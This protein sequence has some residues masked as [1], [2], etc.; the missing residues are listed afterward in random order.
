MKAA[1]IALSITFYCLSTDIVL[2]QESTSKA[3]SLK[4]LH[5]NGWVWEARPIINDL[6]D[7]QG[8]IV[9]MITINQLGKI[10][11]IKVIECTVSEKTEKVYREGTSKL[12]FRR[13]GTA[14]E[15][16]ELVTGTITYNIMNK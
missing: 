8:K 14:T 11:D 2:G 16:H 9:Y 1:I 10:E 13:V 7:D 12:I 4:S 15:T 3:E 6:S 5:E